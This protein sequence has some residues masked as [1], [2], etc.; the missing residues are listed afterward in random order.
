M[1]AKILFLI[2]VGALS[3]GGCSDSDTGM[4]SE[5]KDDP[6][7]EGMEMP[8]TLSVVT[9]KE[10]E[11]A[12]AKTVSGL[13][14]DYGAV[15]AAFNSADTDYTTDKQQAWVH[16]RA[17][18]PLQSVNEILC[19]IGQTGADKLV[20]QTYVALVDA[21]KCKRE[22]QQ[23]SGQDQ[24]SSGGKS[25]EMERWIV[26]SRRADNTSPQTVKIWVP[27][28]GD[29]DSEFPEEIRAEVIIT[30]GVSAAN[31]FGKFTLNF[32]GIHAGTTD[33]SNGF[34]SVVV[35]PGET[36]MTGTLKTVA[37]D[38]GRIG[39]TLFQNAPVWQWTSK[40]S[41]VTDA[42]Q[43]A[44]VAFTG[45]EEPD[46]G[47]AAGSTRQSAHAVAFND[48][49][50]LIKSESAPDVPLTFADLALIDGEG[51]AE[52][53]VCRSRSQF[54]KNTW[55]YDL[56]HGADDAAGKF[57]AGQRVAVNSG[58][59]FRADTDDDSVPDTYGWVGY[60]G[61]WSEKSPAAGWDGA[62]II[63][64][65]YGLDAVEETYTIK[66]TSG[67]M[68]KRS[69]ETLA[70][71]E[72]DGEVFNHHSC[73][74]DA[75]APSGWTCAEYLVEYDNNGTVAHPTSPTVGAGPG[76]Y[77][78]HTLTWTDGPATETP[79]NPP[80]KIDTALAGNEWL[81]MWSRSLGGSVTY[82]NGA[83]NVSFYK[84]TFVDANDA[85]AF[86][87][88]AKLV[89]NCYN[90]CLKAGLTEAEYRDPNAPDMDG[91][92]QGYYPQS[93]DP[94]V[95]AAV[96]EFDP[97]TLGLMVVKVGG[98]DITPAPIVP[99]SCPTCMEGDPWGMRTGAML[100]DGV[101][102]TDVWDAWNAAISYTWETGHNNWNKMTFVTDAAG[103]VVSFD[104]PIAFRYKHLQANDANGAIAGNNTAPY[105]KTFMLE[106]AGSGDLW[107]I[108]W[109]P[110]PNGEWRQEFAIA[111]GV[112][113]GPNGTE[114]RIKAREI[115]LVPV[116][117]DGQCTTLTL[118]QP[119]A[120]LP[121][122][123]DAAPS[124]ANDVA[125]VPDSDTPAVI[126]GE[127]QVVDQGIALKVK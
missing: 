109:Q 20:N 15:I 126:A 99:P 8:V 11:Q 13:S 124:H 101:T 122:A 36:F 45:A 25:V 90:E 58:F 116:R 22:G 51:E 42:T 70:L 84:E 87:A 112:A 85:D 37:T 9:A 30:E 82:V 107:G 1:K 110:T 29:G 111:D 3:L 55:R 105:N 125:P 74:V 7:T 48:T 96:Y 61:M 62:T 88:G 80:V 100:P 66:E 115:E 94:A 57:T 17:L 106:Y 75:A 33:Y 120:A 46:W 26:D 86:P 81:G 113:M 43:T 52:G 77:K 104:P 71:T 24:S 89:L 65:A 97:A 19:F 114:F 118:G 5:N 59:P 69:L 73:E 12:A 92:P 14:V 95:P 10:D 68:I 35:K 53:G 54:R 93:M 23:D 60:W 28:N 119:A 72:L 34:T 40:V 76:F 91:M 49:H 103:K 67:K 79:V 102:V 78:T 64:E 98:F 123:A 39:F 4:G 32:V 18:E 21:A 47:G 56:Y 38:D 121:T 83:T 27:E 2:V 63:K 108:P 6:N 31:P 127:V 117:V 44:G 50:I 16:D 41:V